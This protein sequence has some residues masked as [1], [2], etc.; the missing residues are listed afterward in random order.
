MEDVKFVNCGKGKEFFFI[1][2]GIDFWIFLMEKFRLVFI[3][4]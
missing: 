3:C 2:E 1:E 4:F